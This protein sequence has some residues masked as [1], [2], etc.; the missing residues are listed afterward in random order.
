MVKLGKGIKR[1][2]AEELGIIARSK[3]F[4]GEAGIQKKKKESSVQKG[5]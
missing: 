1:T 4:K 3:I 2:V 5:A